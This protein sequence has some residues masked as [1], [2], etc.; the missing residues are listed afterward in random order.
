MKGIVVVLEAII[1]SIILISVF[2]FF[3]PRYTFKDKWFDRSSGLLA[4]DALLTIERTG[5]LQQLLSNRKAM[6]SF[7]TKI[8]PPPYDWWMIVKFPN[9]TIAVVH[10]FKPKPLQKSQEAM[11][12]YISKEVK[13]PNPSFEDG[14][15][16]NAYYWVEGTGFNRSSDNAYTGQ[17]SMKSNYTGLESYSYSTSIELEPN[18]NYLLSAYIYDSLVDGQVYV[19]LNDTTFECELIPTVKNVWEYLSCNFTT[20]SVVDSVNIR[21]G[22]KNVTAGDVWFDDVKIQKYSPM[23]LKLVVGYPY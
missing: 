2:A 14:N 23:A 8:L 21:L 15:L 22:V 17:Y 3:F 9:G 18:T 19:D 16:G 7:L 10:D 6:I 20:P 11:Y 1:A 4:R 5:R 13:N 12:V